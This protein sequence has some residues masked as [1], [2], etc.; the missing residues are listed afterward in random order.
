MKTNTQ[1]INAIANLAQPKP[2]DAIQTAHFLAREIV[3]YNKSSDKLIE[4]QKQIDDTKNE[5]GTRKKAID[6]LLREL[7][8]NNVLMV[9]GKGVTKCPI[10]IALKEVLS[11]EELAEKT[12]A[13]IC[14]AVSYALKEKK[15]YDIKYLEKKAQQKKIDDAKKEGAKNA[16]TPTATTPTATTPTATTPTATTPTTPTATTPTATTPTAITKKSTKLD[17]CK[18]ASAI[19][20]LLFDATQ[21]KRYDDDVNDN[22]IMHYNIILDSI[23]TI[24]DTLVLLSKQDRKIVDAMHDDDIHDDDIHDDD[25]LGIDSELVD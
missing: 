14:G 23:D 25:N 20:R 3:G 11:K 5:K 15:P 22:D 19:T 10:R 18:D 7:W 24:M 4:L 12:I 1:Q 9:E 8:T 16:T 6:G 21:I 13:N 17:Y 2:F